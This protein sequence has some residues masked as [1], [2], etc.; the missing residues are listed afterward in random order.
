MKKLFVF[1]LDFTLWNTGG[2]WV[3]CTYP[4][5][6]VKNGEIID[7]GGNRMK[8]YPDSLEILT[9][10]RNENRII[11]V[12]SRTNEPSWAKDLIQLMNIGHFFD[13]MEIYPSSK[14]NHLSRISKKSGIPFSEMV[15]FDDEHRN[16][17]DAESIG[18]EAVYVKNGLQ[19]RMV[20]KFL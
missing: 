11:A 20:K 13:Y 1:D 4:P 3:D 18:I 12:A 10:L 8:L 14:I 15:F 6:S 19:L 16:I 9:L 5:Y 17:R 2:V 7:S